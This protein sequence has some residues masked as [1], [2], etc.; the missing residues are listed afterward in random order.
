MPRR[1][2]AEELSK[3]GY[4][5]T[6]IA[7]GSNTDAWQPAERRLALTRGILEVLRDF[8]HPVSIVTKSALIE[9]DIDLLAELAAER[10]V[11]VMV[12]VTTLDD[13][14][15][16]RMEPRTAG[17]KRRLEVIRRLAAAGI[18][19]GVMAA[20]MIPVSTTTTGDDCSRAPR[21]RAPA[22]PAGCS[23]ASR[24]K[25]VLFTDWIE[26]HYPLRAAGFSA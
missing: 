22:S 26:N 14:L 4:R 3:P 9:R 24:T 20:P 1:S 8:H 2:C 5:C 13:E 17:G 10:L 12:S 25:W 6:P 21:K 11:V 18:P 7:L 16:R 23:C 15:K 19:C